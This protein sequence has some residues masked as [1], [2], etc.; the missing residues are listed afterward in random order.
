MVKERRNRATE[1]AAAI[2]VQTAQSSEAALCQGVA[3]FSLQYC[4][5]CCRPI[6]Q[7]MVMLSV[8]SSLVHKSGS[9]GSQCHH[10]HQRCPRRGLLALS[11]TSLAARDRPTDTDTVSQTDRQWQHSGSPGTESISIREFRERKVPPQHY[12]LAFLLFSLATRL[13]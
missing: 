4:C 3:P 8:C 11:V 6:F 9:N 12:H 7:H 5:C 10:H 2:D 13:V 1:P